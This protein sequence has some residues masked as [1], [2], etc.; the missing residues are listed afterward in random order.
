MGL[1]HSSVGDLVQEHCRL[2]VFISEFLG[3]LVRIL[4]FG[5]YILASQAFEVLELELEHEP[6]WEDFSEHG[7]SWVLPSCL[8]P[9]HSVYCTPSEPLDNVT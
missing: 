5:D 1:Y 8:F 2:Q 3:G 4:F 9:R 6:H 7:R